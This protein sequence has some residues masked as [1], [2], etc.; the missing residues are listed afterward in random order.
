MAIRFEEN[1]TKLPS[2]LPSLSSLLPSLPSSLSPPL[3]FPLSPPLSPLLSPP[4]LSPLL[5]P[6]LSPLLSPS[7]SPLLSPSLSHLL[8]PSLSHSLL[9]LLQIHPFFSLSPS[10]SSILFNSRASLSLFFH[11]SF[12]TFLFLPLRRHSCRVAACELMRWRRRGQRVV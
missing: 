12:K 6:S 2:F 9:R 1:Q 5:S 7:L 8:S 10:L 3:S 11:S 4:S